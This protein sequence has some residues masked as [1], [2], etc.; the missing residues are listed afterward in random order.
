MAE[1]NFNLF[2]S[3]LKIN[4]SEITLATH[5][6]KLIHL[7]NYSDLKKDDLEKIT[8]QINHSFFFSIII[9]ENSNK[10]MQFI[11]LN[12]LKHWHGLLSL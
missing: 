6:Q 10:N 2:L 5:I 12:P 8:A 4:N 3:L 7:N 1:N 11:L 9:P